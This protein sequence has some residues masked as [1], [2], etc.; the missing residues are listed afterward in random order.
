MLQLYGILKCLLKP[1]K[2]EAP[3][4]SDRVALTTT[5]AVHIPFRMM[6]LTVILRC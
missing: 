1:S 6:G 4:S 5:D 3:L 2:L